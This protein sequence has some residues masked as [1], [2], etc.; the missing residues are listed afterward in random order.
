MAT[1]NWQPSLDRG[2]LR[3]KDETIAAVLRFQYLA[4]ASLAKLD[5]QCELGLE[6]LLYLQALITEDGEL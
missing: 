3:L 2:D 4:P 5:M 6:R 1:P